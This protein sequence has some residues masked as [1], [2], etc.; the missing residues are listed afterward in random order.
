MKKINHW[1]I[2]ALTCITSLFISCVD[3][4]KF[5]NA[6][7]EKAPGGSVTKDTVFNSAEYT[8]QFLTGL[9]SLQ[10]YGLPFGTNDAFPFMHTGW[11]GKWENLSDHWHT[12]WDGQA[13]QTRYYTGI[14]NSG[15]NKREE[16]F[17]YSRMNV[18]EAIRYGW[19]LIENI[20]EVPDMDNAEK[21]Q[22][23]AQ[24][25]CIIA[26]R[27][28]DTFRHYGGLPIV[29]GSFTGTDATYELP[30]GTVE[31]TV[32]FMIELL[33]DASKVLPWQVAVSA[34][35]A[36][37]W[38]KAGAMGLKTSILL[39]AASPLFND[40]APYSSA[41]PQD[42]VQNL[43]V[44]YGG[45][46]PELWDRCL[47]ACEE[48]FTELNRNGGYQLLQAQGTRPSDYRLAFR[49]AY[50]RLDSPEILHSTRV[51]TYEGS[52][53][54]SSTYTWH[55]WQKNNNR[56]AYN[57]TQDYV[58]LFPWADGTPFVWQEAEQEGKLDEM[59]IKRTNDPSQGVDLTRDPRLYETAIVNGLP[60][61]LDWTTGNMSGNPYE[62]WVGGY[63]AREAPSNETGRFATG[64]TL[65]KYYLEE[66]A[67]NQDTHWSYLR[68]PEV[69]LN[70]AEVL[71]HAGRLQDA[72]NLVDQI[73]ARVNLR[74]LVESNPGKN[75]TSNKDALLEE[76]LRERACELG[77][78]DVRFFD[79]IRYKMK[80][81]F[82]KQLYRLKITRTDKPGQWFGADK[83]SGVPW[84]T[85]E[86]ERLPITSPTR[87]WW[88]QGFDSKWYLSPFTLG[89]LNKGYGL[90][91]NPGW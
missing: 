66:D 90:V 44:W 83:D 62:L 73:R 87:I 22:I 61:T 43:N 1:L 49:K 50:F 7:L 76:I 21:E 91:Q 20:D 72:I 32:D 68:L 10:Y 16:K 75:L 46:K 85:F 56:M 17:E 30:R 63:D 23:I 3:D 13:I 80:N 29:R 42:A 15:Y 5:G 18:W 28:W 12:S 31:E 33:D 84:P 24:T 88:T 86:Y 70:Y 35:D 59:F 65:M 48:F 54:N 41:S 6:F 74:G 45:Y 89:E 8:R 11:V 25:K 36:G 82:E 38:T 52:R 53:F 64:Y 47:T 26:S 14:H 4:F 77:M 71:C 39:F 78:E 9:Y 69:M 55:S 40:T 79:M 58:E 57:P 37:R 51:Q 34:N 81:Q 19:L 60:K 67:G 2:I 27:Y